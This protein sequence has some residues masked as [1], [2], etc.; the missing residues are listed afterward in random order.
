MKNF[1][2][3]L[4]QL[5]DDIVSIEQR[6]LAFAGNPHPKYFESQRNLLHYIALR[7]HDLRPL[8][9]E[10]AVLGLSSLGRMESHVLASIDAVVAALHS[11]DGQT[12]RHLKTESDHQLNFQLGSQLLERHG[13]DLLGAVPPRRTVRIMVTLPSEAEH[14]YTLIHSLL[15]ARHGRR[16]D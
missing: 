8:Q 12:T 9:H 4:E 10:L 11:L 7:S 6:Y 2:L 15:Q 3:Q 1:I 16:Q 14:D 13:R 5:R